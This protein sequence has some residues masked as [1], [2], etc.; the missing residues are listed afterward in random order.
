MSQIESI[1]AREI[2]DSR[3]TPTVEVEIF[4]ETGIFGR[5]AV[6]SGASTG[7]REALELRDKSK[8]RYGG[9]G[10]LQAVANV[11][12]IIAPH[13]LGFESLLQPLLDQTLIELDN[14]VNKKRNP[15]FCSLTLTRQLC[16]LP[17]YRL[18]DILASLGLEGDN[19]HDAMDDTKATVNLALY[20][21]KKIDKNTY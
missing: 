3:G 14:S 9:K 13:L 5:A 15:S 10:V 18:G 11:N 1:I 21:K 19:T 4:L 12:E 2:F 7:K 16:K 20:L 6:P 17:S 8:I